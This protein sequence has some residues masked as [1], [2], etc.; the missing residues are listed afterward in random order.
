MRESKFIEQN[1]QKWQ[2]FE[3][4]LLDP[5][6]TPESLRDMFVQVTD[7]LSF[8]RTYY[9][10]RSVR[11][12]LNGLAQQ[13]N[14]RI[15]RG[16]RF[17][18]GRF[19]RFW[20]AEMPQVLW[21]AR[22]ALAWSLGIFAFA[23]FIGVASTW[24]EPEFARSILGDDYINMT[25]EN[26]KKGDP[27]A[28]YKQSGAASMSLGI[29][30][31]N[32]WVAFLTAIFG[33]L[34]SVGTV[35]LLL[36]NG[37]MLGAFQYFFVQKGLFWES[38]LTIWIHGTL[39]ISA[40]VVAGAAGMTAGSGLLFPG[41][42]R[43]MQAFQLSARRGLKIFIGLVP[44]F[45][46][47]AFF[48][49]FLTRFTETPPLVRGAFI[50][51]SALFVG[52]YFWWLPRKL[53]RRGQFTT[54]LRDRQPPPDRRA[55]LNFS[56]IK[57]S[58]E[59]FSEAFVLL[60]INAARA[61][62]SA[63]GASLIFTVSSSWLVGEPLAE[64]FQFPQKLFGVAAGAAGFFENQKLFVLQILLF[65]AT[66]WLA[67]N[68][69]RRVLPPGNL[70]QFSLGQQLW[71]A[72][73][74][75]IPAAIFALIFSKFEGFWAWLGL[76]AALPVGSLF[77][78]VVTAE[79]PQIF[80]GSD[81]V[82]RLNRWSVSL[83]VGLMLAGF[84]SLLLLFLDSPLFGVLSEFLALNIQSGGQNMATFH[85]ALLTVLVNAVFH[86]M[87]WLSMFCG[88]LLYFS[89]REISDASSLRAGISE[90]GMGRQI[91]GLPRE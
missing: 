71:A 3:E 29:A 57:T 75:A 77:A 80:L 78:F 73:L 23:V 68:G 63:V 20:A 17:P 19:W 45:L 39:E 47:A 6:P 67:L 10:N 48:E 21:E 86:L 76:A 87:L 91:R 32:L 28:V 27:M 42:L 53:A 60:K 25:L 5:N 26:I 15:F 65:S 22:A 31:N 30:L 18:V 54:S 62:A 38:F 2:Q 55:P 79:T 82:F 37:V 58:G 11:V 7:D 14:H 46:L 72:V 70:P 35:F 84:G 44:V 88:G 81:R 66:S 85:T 51:V 50:A 90:I 4:T 16:K 74:L 89:F 40:I 34:A 33:V 59:I 49:G 61:L 43:R 56:E 24:V 36:Q 69:L 8:A 83:G 41:T 13:V 1:R 64:A 12:Y 52:W 9:P